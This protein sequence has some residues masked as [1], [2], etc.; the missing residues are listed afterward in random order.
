MRNALFSAFAWYA[1]S[2]KVR[3]WQASVAIY[4]RAL[5]Q[6][7]NVNETE[8]E[9]ECANGKLTDASALCKPDTMQTTNKNSVGRE[10]KKKKMKIRFFFFGFAPVG[11]CHLHVIVAIV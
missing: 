2:G 5:A 7:E 4:R 11:L 9:N 10:R 1:T 6:V 3:H 8:T